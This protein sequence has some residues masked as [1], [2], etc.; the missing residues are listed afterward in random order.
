MKVLSFA[1]Q[2]SLPSSEGLVGLVFLC[3]DDRKLLLLESG[4]WWF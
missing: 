4:Q 2:I 1:H 3:Y